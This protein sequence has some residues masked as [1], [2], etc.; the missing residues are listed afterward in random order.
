MI[1]TACIL[2]ALL[3]GFC[4]FLKP[5]KPVPA[6]GPLHLLFPLVHLNSSPLHSLGRLL[7]VIQVIT[8]QDWASVSSQLDLGLR[9]FQVQVLVLPDI[10]CGT[11]SRS[12]GLRFFI[13]SLGLPV[14]GPWN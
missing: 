6:A 10:S 4:L 3:P 11:L 13:Y 5:S 1:G 9:Q 8:S 12:L 2:G 14:R 7:F